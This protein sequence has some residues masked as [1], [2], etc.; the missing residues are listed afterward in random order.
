MVPAGRAFGP[1]TSYLVG[2]QLAGAVIGIRGDVPS[3]FV[4]LS[5]DLFAGA[6]IYKPTGF[7]DVPCDGGPAGDSQALTRTSAKT[8]QIARHSGRKTPIQI[9]MHRPTPAE[10]A[11]APHTTPEP[12]HLRPRAPEFPHLDLQRLSQARSLS[13]Q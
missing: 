4:A 11:T 9:I 8:T 2:T 6:P 7:S 12:S 5:Y 13:R 1:N 10:K 3:R